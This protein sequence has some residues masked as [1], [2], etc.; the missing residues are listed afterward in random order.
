M[1][2]FENFLEDFL[3]HCN[4]DSKHDEYSLQITEKR[5]VACCGLLYAALMVIA[6]IF[7]LR[8]QLILARTE[9]VKQYFTSWA[10]LTEQRSD[11]PINCLEY[12]IEQVTTPSK[13][14]FAIVKSVDDPIGCY[15]VID[16][17]C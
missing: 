8:L 6:E 1:H 12:R 13:I 11:A 7:L 16:P 3:I 9:S 4:V 2:D 5:L 10:D 15:P 17:N 14:K